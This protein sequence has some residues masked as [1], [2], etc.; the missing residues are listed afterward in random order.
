MDGVEQTNGSVRLVFRC[1]S[2]AEKVAKEDAIKQPWVV[3]SAF[4]IV[5]GWHRSRGKCCRASH[6]VR[7]VRKGGEGGDTT[8]PAGLDP[9]LFRRFTVYL[10]WCMGSFQ[11]ARRMLAPLAHGY[12]G[13]LRPPRQRRN[14]AAGGQTQ[15]SRGA[16]AVPTP[17]LHKPQIQQMQPGRD[18]LG[19]MADPA[20]REIPESPLARPPLGT[21]MGVLGISWGT[22]SENQK[23]TGGSGFVPQHHISA[24]FRFRSRGHQVPKALDGLGSFIVATGLAASPTSGVV[25][26]GLAV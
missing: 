19:P 20:L 15:N 26:M 3:E 23:P 24:R 17:V 8:K 9:G 12:Q 18:M 21:F 4:G 7:G 5:G 6:H 2:V 1:D 25:A 11:R 14:D 10:G 16:D 13:D 22:Y